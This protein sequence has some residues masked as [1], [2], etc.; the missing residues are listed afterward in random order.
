MEA[1]RVARR[2]NA[3]LS[4]LHAGAMTSDKVA[5]F[6]E[7]FEDMGRKDVEIYWCEGAT[8]VEA[9]V[10][11]AA[12]EQF[13]L[14]V[15]GTVSRA[16]NHR[17]F[18]GSIVRELFSRTPCDLLLIPDP[19]EECGDSLSACLLLDAHTPRWRAAEES[20][21]SLKPSKLSI[22]AADNPFAAAKSRRGEP[23]GESL[24]EIAEKLGEIA[25][26]VDLRLVTSNTGFVLCDILQESPPD[27]LLVES[28]WVNRHR[29]LPSHLGW[30]EQVIPGRLFLFGKPPRGTAGPMPLASA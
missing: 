15:A 28:E 5:T 3:R 21:R 24:E 16:E 20:L 12:T 9:L 29:V 10:H 6:G 13:D 25:P 26:E 27:F 2:F 18:T 22:L 11:T 1:D 23:E 8:P 19:Q 7:V 4:V 14:F 30:L 17:N